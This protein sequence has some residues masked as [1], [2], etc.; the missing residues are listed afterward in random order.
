MGRRQK[1]SRVSSAYCKKILRHFYLAILMKLNDTK[2][3]KF[4]I[5][6]TS[7]ISS[8][9][10]FQKVIKFQV[11]YFDYPINSLLLHEAKAFRGM[12]LLY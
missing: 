10:C 1:K 2:T 12:V 5:A 4:I 9:I 8:F 11:A 3:M 7:E 6:K